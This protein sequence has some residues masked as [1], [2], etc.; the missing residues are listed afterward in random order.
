[1]NTRD[2]YRILG[3]KS[4]VSLA[5]VKAAYRRLAM[6]YHPDINIEDQQ[7]QIKFIEVT[8]AY[9]FLLSAKEF[10]QASGQSNH[11]CTTPTS[12]QAHSQSRVKQPEA[13]HSSNSYSGTARAKVTRQEA[14][15]QVD[16]GLLEVNQQI[17]QRTYRHLQQLLKDQQFPRAIA[18]AEGL[19]QRLPHDPEVRQWQAITYQW[20]GH[21]L[22]ETKKFDK[23][24][25][26]LKKALRTDPHNKSLW[27]AV[28][29]DFRRIE[30][31]F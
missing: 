21:Y 28:E 15:F 4:G 17:K 3:L 7:A 5:E 23:A 6:R 30:Q 25:V 22:I 12:S 20:W 19:A 2:C 10:S 13:S 24:R 1:M 27:A 29:R 11:F 14:P 31:A 26:F 9:K 16:P 8:E 18:L